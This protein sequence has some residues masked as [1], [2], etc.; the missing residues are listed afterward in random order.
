MFLTKVNL[1]FVVPSGTCNTKGGHSCVFPFK[2]KNTVFKRCIEGPGS[3]HWCP[4]EINAD[5]TPKRRD[6]CE[7]PNCYEQP[8]TNGVYAKGNLIIL[9]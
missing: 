9:T 7:K 8:N 2:Y 5:L 1:Y 3:K 4:Y 6:W